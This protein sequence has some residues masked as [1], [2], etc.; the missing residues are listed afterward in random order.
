M[1]GF[2]NN[3]SIEGIQAAVPS[4]IVDNMMFADILGER[5]CKK[6]LRLTGVKERHLCKSGQTSADLAYAAGS[7]LL[8]NLGWT[9]DSVDVLIFVTQN[10]LFSLPSTAFILQKKM[11][12]NKNCMAFD[13]NLGCSGAT[14]GIQ[15]IASLLQPARLGARGLLLMS[16]ND[17]YS[18][19][20]DPNIM[21]E[22]MLFGVAGCAVAL[23]KNEGGCSIH[24]RSKSDGVRYRAIMR[25]FS[26]HFSMD[27]ES[28]FEFAINDV[29][30]DIIDFQDDLNLKPQDID[31]YI[32]HQAQALMLSTMDEVCGIPAEKE[33]RS[34][35][36][37]GN[38]SSSSIPLT[39]CVNVQELQKRETVNVLMCGFGVGLSWS[40]VY[41]SIRS[42]KVFPVIPADEIYSWDE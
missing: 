13:I 39:L 11:K 28:V 10:P 30:N 17:C 37:Y 26:G 34:L 5:R 8:E 27:G 12:L 14:I 3:I 7:K 25:D 20:A 33:L 42:D 6:Q 9:P 36:N 29:A 4:K 32:F 18:E 38:T 23:Q 1:Q 19:N 31:Y 41:T 16:E 40:I 35:E 2:F 21:A 22:K 15:T 24:F